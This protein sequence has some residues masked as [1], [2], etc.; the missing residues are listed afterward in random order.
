MKRGS[1]RAAAPAPTGSP[2]SARLLAQEAGLA[3]DPGAAADLAA[4]LACD[5]PGV[6]ATALWA[7]GRLR[8]GEHLDAIVRHLGSGD[9]RIARPAIWA[10]GQ[11]G[12]AAAVTALTARLRE[13]SPALLAPL[14]VA[15][16][17]VPRSLALDALVPLLHDP[18]GPTRSRVSQV[19]I[20]LGAPATEA[21]REHLARDV[22]TCPPTCRRAC[23]H[24]LAET[25]IT[26]EDGAALMQLA[27]SSDVRTRL[28]A[29]AG[30]GRL[31]GVGGREFLPSF[32]ADERRDVREA[33]RRALVARPD[34]RAGEAPEMPVPAGATLPPGTPLILRVVP[35]LEEIALGEALA[36]G[37][38]PLPVRGHGYVVVTWGGLLAR[39]A[40]LRTVEDIVLDGGPIEGTG[41]DL[42]QALALSSS[43]AGTS[44]L[45]HT[46]YLRVA[47]SREQRDDL[48]ERVRRRLHHLGVSATLEPGARAEVTLDILGR[49]TGSDAPDRLRV[50]VRLFARPPGRRPLAGGDVPASLNATVAAALVR[51]LAPHGSETFLDPMCGAG[52]ILRERAAVEPPPL[53]LLG[54]DSDE[55]SLQRA[56][57]TLAGAATLRRWDAGDL[58]IEA[59]TVD[60]VACNPPYGRRTGSHARNRALYPRMMAEFSRVLHTGGRAAIITQEKRLLEAQLHGARWRRHGTW[61]VEVGGLTPTIYVIE[62]V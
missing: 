3:R 1:R 20:R 49:Y 29:I 33:A 61:R 32:L 60:R 14:L 7:L 9:P 57:S 11:I 10:A 47:G 6:V 24:I 4:L 41:L 46:A 48:R 62:R 59:E 45:P 28:H 36:L 16:D 12:T 13:V 8:A 35:G 17:H 23:A 56:Q 55:H 51:L 58:P 44:A 19:L 50:G 34:A 22:A 43:V 21:V 26:A 39:V 38:V 5:D 37:A 42:Q 31:E 27:S 15:F 54:G 52:T 18:D 30:L 40:T 2:A 25:A 53:L